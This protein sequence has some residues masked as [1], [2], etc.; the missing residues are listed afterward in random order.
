MLKVRLTK[1]GGDSLGITLPKQALQQLRWFQG[2]SI[3]LEIGDKSITVTNFAERTVG[4]THRRI[5]CGD[6][7]T[8][9]P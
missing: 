9:R 3:L 8:R 6:S 5:E 7:I 2:D 4:T 1:I